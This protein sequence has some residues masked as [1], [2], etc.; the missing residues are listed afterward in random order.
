MNNVALNSNEID[1]IFNNCECINIDAC[2][3]ENLQFEVE[4]EQFIWD[5]HHKNLMKQYKLKDFYLKVNCGVKVHFHH[6]TRTIPT[7]GRTDSIF[8]DAERCI[9]RL[10]NSNDLCHI[11]INGVCY[12]VPWKDKA[13]DASLCGTPIT[14]YV[15]KWHT[16]SEIKNNNNERFIE[17]KIK[18]DENER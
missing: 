7:W 10:L 13:I 18:K 15:N 2:A 16:A 1:L 11:Y 14:D 5:K 8:T 17:I 4:S 12:H 3:I 6:P 9:E